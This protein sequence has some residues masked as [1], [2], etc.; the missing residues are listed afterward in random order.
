[1]AQHR[2]R[3]PVTIVQTTLGKI[4]DLEDADKSRYFVNNQVQ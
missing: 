3:L 4:I 2:E 1:M